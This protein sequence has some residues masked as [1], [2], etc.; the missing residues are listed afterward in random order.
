[1]RPILLLG[2]DRWHCHSGGHQGSRI[3]PY[4]LP[5]GKALWVKFGF[6][7]TLSPDQKSGPKGHFGPSWLGTLGPTVAVTPI[8]GGRPGLTV[9]WQC[10]WAVVVYTLGSRHF[11][12]T[13]L[14]FPPARSRRRRESRPV[15]V[16]GGAGREEE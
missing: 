1:M 4:S 10:H 8:P 11:L 9:S 12:T 16:V 13:A 14:V 15:R 3:T 6:P 2:S 5:D 7:G